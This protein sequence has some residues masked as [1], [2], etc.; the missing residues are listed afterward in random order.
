MGTVQLIRGAGQ[1]GIAERSIVGN[2]VLG[3]PLKQ[4]ASGDVM[5]V[6]TVPT[7]APYADI[8]EYAVKL[9]ENH[10]RGIGERGKDNG[11]LILLALQERR[12][13]VEV[14]YGLEGAIP[15]VAAYRVIQE[16][17]VPRFREGDFAGGIEAAVGV[18]RAAGSADTAATWS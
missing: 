13:Q 12:V 1:P 5:V 16:Y 18:L 11:V 3:D 2:E 15:D 7:Y 8:R 14:G 10:G 17:L 9:F 4:A 6:V